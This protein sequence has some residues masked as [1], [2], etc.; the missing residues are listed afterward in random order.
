M[1]NMCTHKIYFWD[2]FLQNK[3]FEEKNFLEKKNSEKNLFFILEAAM[4]AMIFE[5][6][7]CNVMLTLNL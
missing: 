6:V 3:N 4:S 1:C 5:S 7:M 2:F